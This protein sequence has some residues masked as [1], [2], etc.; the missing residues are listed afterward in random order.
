M[1]IVSR[2]RRRGKRALLLPTDV[3]LWLLHVDVLAGRLRGLRTG[4]VICRLPLA[5]H[6]VP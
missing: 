2:R 1:G 6:N 4:L 3:D 5:E